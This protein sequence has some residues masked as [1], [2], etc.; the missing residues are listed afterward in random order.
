MAQANATNMPVSAGRVNRQDVASTVMVVGITLLALLLGLL[1]RNSVEAS[2][3]AYTDPAGVGIKYP[4]T[5]HLDDSQAANGIVRV[6]AVRTGGSPTVL[7]VQ[8]V[9]VD[10]SAP[11]TTTLTAVANDLAA[12]R[13]RDLTAFKLFNITTKDVRIKGLPGAKTEYVYVT[14]PGNAIR[15]TIPSV[16]IGEDWLVHKGD[17]VY[18]FSYQATEANRDEARSVF[19]KFVESAQ[20][21]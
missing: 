8:R 6:T 9:V 19:E 15:Q 14:N 1:L 13:A 17:K 16:M 10:A 5:W 4:N 11:T 7:E 2:T 18:V 20:L 12:T 21:P 3:V